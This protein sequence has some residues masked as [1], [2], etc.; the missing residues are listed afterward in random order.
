MERFGLITLNLIILMCYCLPMDTSFID[1]MKNN[2]S[3]LVSPR[4]TK[5]HTRST[6]S[7]TGEDVRE[8]KNG[9]WR[10]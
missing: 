4:K 9:S 6:T 2:S 1:L 5:P 3:H 7:E 8:N 10:G